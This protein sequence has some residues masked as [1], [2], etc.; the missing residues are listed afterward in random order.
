MNLH[1]I[2]MDTY[3]VIPLSLSRE[4]ESIRVYLFGNL[5]R[6][7]IQYTLDGVLKMDFLLEL[8]NAMKHFILSI[9]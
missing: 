9:T 6:Y 1:N 7:Q 3:Q 8:T 4:V 2:I 5:E